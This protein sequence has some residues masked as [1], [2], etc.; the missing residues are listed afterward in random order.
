MHLEPLAIAITALACAA[1]SYA[2]DSVIGFLISV[3][4]AAIAHEEFSAGKT[5]VDRGEAGQR[6]EGGEG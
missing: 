6:A 2:A 1:T 4:I 3:V 5:G